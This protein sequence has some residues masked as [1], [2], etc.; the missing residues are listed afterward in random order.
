LSDEEFVLYELAFHL[1]KTAYE[2]QNEMTYDEF[3]KWIDYFDR[4][5]FGWR[6]DLRFAMI[7]QIAGDKRKPDQIYPS[8]AAIF[9]P[10][11]REENPLKGIKGSKMFAGML[12]A[13][14]GHKLDILK[15]L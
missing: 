10:I 3:L 11:E 5:P 14:G 8:L 2:L 1:G 7:M 4:R 9:K 15:D 12:S 13:K 6:E